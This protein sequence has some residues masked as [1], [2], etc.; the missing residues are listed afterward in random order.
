MGDSVMKKP[1]V[2]AMLL[3]VFSGE[4]TSGEQVRAEQTCEDYAKFVQHV[5]KTIAIE[6]SY[7]VESEESFV[8]APGQAARLDFEDNPSGVKEF[9]LFYNG[10]KVHLIYRYTDDTEKQYQGTWLSLENPKAYRSTRASGATTWLHLFYEFKL[11]DGKAFLKFRTTRSLSEKDQEQIREINEASRRRRAAERQAELK[12]VSELEWDFEEKVKPLKIIMDDPND[13]N[14]V[15]LRNEYD[16]E[17]LVSSAKD[18][19]EKLRLIT[20]WVQK[21]WRHSGNNKPSKSDPLTILKEA[22]EGKRFRCVEYAKVVAGCARSLGMPARTLGLKRPDVETAKS[23]AGHVVAEVW[24]EQFNKWVFVDGQ[25]G[26]I[27]EADGIPLNAVEFQDAIARENPGLKIRFAA[28]KDEIE[29][30]AWVA[31]YLCYFDFNLNQ[32]LYNAE[33]EE[34]RIS[35]SKGK[36]MLVPRGVK[37]PKVFQR[38]FPITNCTYIS[39]PKVFYPQMSN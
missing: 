7:R 29:Y 3:V 17:G 16:L 10:E 14:M 9:I 24:L 11:K 39:N 25:W 31:H 13:P 19:Y 2:I 32:R 23:G 5:K 27:P 20:G 33:T 38:K 22:S 36:V 30:L 1:I 21:Q 37:K 6:R 35:G 28:K 18:D 12:A 34:E 8:L 4:L 15:K 26:A